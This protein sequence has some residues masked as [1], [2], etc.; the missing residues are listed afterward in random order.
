MLLASPAAAAEPGVPFTTGTLPPPP[1]LRTGMSA[2]QPSAQNL[3]VL[4]FAGDLGFSGN[5]DVPSAD[6]AVKHG[7][8]IPWRQLGGSVST[9]LAAD[10]NFANLETVIS[11]SRNLT[12][13]EKSYTFLGDPAALR[14]VVDMGFNVL[15]AANN[16]AQ[17]FGPDG[18]VE[19]LSYL[20]SAKAHGLKAHAGL[21]I[22]AARYE[23][24]RFDLGQL[25]I[26]LAAIGLAINHA[27]PEGP[28]QALYASPRDFERIT[29]G[30]EATDG[31]IRV[32]SVHYGKELV[33]L[34]GER[35]MVR[36]RNAVDSGAAQIVFGHH[37]HVASGIE[38][39]GDNLILYGLGNFTHSGTQD[40]SRY[41]ACRDFGLYAKVYISA[42]ASKSA[43]IRAVE[44]FPIRGTHA[45]PEAF[46]AMEAAQRIA[47]VNALNRLVTEKDR[48]PLWLDTT[49]RASGLACFGDQSTYGDELA[50]RCRAASGAHAQSRVIDSA[51]LASCGSAPVAPAA[52]PTAVVAEQPPV[53]A[54][55]PARRKALKAVAAGE[56]PKAKSSFFQKLF[57]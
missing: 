49:S 2:V 50:A 17:D 24:A 51:E 7:A 56:K 35:D 28:G 54:P 12:P 37:S 23:P 32:L 18:V 42:D 9:L 27:G 55:K 43:A 1:S 45:V 53:P 31:D 39:R 20:A 11:A 38:R 30:L 10:A 33:S 40:M 29:S 48:Q 36:F 26:G 46:P 14:A 41:G 52:T 16:H 5:G 4:G 47:M 6:G 57:D 13:I 25:R 44:V 34:P 3:I 22:G 8:I 21:G 15:T 19:T